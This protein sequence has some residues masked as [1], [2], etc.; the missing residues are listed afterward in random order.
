MVSPWPLPCSHVGVR[1]RAG[2]SHPGTQGRG[3]EIGSPAS[4]ILMPGQVC[5]RLEL[6]VK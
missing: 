1:G 2:F 4:G 5:Y 3:T 6:S